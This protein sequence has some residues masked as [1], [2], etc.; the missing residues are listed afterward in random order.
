MIHLACTCISH[1]RHLVCIVPY[2]FISLCYTLWIKAQTSVPFQVRLNFAHHLRQ[3]GRHALTRFPCREANHSDRSP[4]PSKVYQ[5]HDLAQQRPR[6]WLREPRPC[7]VGDGKS[8]II[9]KRYIGGREKAD[10]ELAA[11]AAGREPK[12]KSPTKVVK[13]VC[14]DVGGVG[15]EREAAPSAWDSCK[16]GLRRQS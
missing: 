7:N 13:K 2:S 15:G 14:L 6:P 4:S 5:L 3:R 9:W 11:D 1:A 8:R 12:Y 16:R 10:E